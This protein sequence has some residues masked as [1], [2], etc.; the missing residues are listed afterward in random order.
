MDRGQEGTRMREILKNMSKEEIVKG[1]NTQ[2][3]GRGKYRPNMHIDSN[4]RLPK[5]SDRSHLPPSIKI[6][7]PKLSKTPLMQDTLSKAGSFDPDRL[8]PQQ[9]FIAADRP[10]LNGVSPTMPSLMPRP[11]K[12]AS[13]SPSGK[14]LASPLEKDEALIQK[15]DKQTERFIKLMN[16]DINHKLDQMHSK[17]EE[18]M[19]QRKR[20]FATKMS[21]PPPPQ[22]VLVTSGS[23]SMKKTIAILEGGDG[24]QM[25][26]KVMFQIENE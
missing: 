23:M 25:R 2:P 10:S 13:I 12:P 20:Q 5:S 1:N 19:K 6:N 21:N 8:S 9:R 11:T 22:G 15:R 14:N 17:F 4:G 16:T 24:S 7:S 3:S 18:R 26:R